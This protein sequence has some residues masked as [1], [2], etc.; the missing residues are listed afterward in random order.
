MTFLGALQKTRGSGIPSSV[1]CQPKCVDHFFLRRVCAS[2]LKA[3]S[4]GYDLAE[5][6]GK[7]ICWLPG[8]MVR[9]IMG[10]GISLESC[11]DGILPIQIS[12][13]LCASNSSPQFMLKNKRGS[14][15]MGGFR[16][17]WWTGLDMKSIKRW[18]CRDMGQV[19]GKAVKGIL[20]NG[21]K[22]VE[23]ANIWKQ[24]LM[25]TTGK[26]GFQWAMK[27][28]N[29]RSTWECGFCL[30]LCFQVLGDWGQQVLR[31]SFSR[32]MKGVFRGSLYMRS[33]LYEGKKA[34]TTAGLVTLHLQTG[35]QL[36]R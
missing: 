20:T 15:M 6:E 9:N 28:L 30:Q 7:S 26:H 14:F 4:C 22:E 13:R 8:S 16:I 31:L 32:H 36:E 17:Y 19:G 29:L 27:S 25:E 24:K 21:E 18:R 11:P 10:E 33:T 5:Y 23:R 35:E 34:E 2:F 3:L 1:S 12:N